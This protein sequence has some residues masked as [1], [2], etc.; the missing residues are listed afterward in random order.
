MFVAGNRMVLFSTH[1]FDMVEQLCSRVV[2]LSNGRIVA[3][4]DVASVRDGPSS[5]EELF[6]RATGQDDFTPLARQILNLVQEN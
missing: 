1:R 5:L 3:E 6:V 4:H 2:I